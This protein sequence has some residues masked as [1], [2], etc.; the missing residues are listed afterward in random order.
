[1]I[2]VLICLK[3]KTLADVVKTG[4]KQFPEF[5]AH[6]VPAHNLVDLVSDGGYHAVMVDLDEAQKPDGGLIGHVRDTNTN[7]EIMAIGDRAL[8]EKFN[9]VKVDHN[10][11]SCIGLPLDPFELARRIVRLGKHLT[12]RHPLSI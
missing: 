8:K 10:I 1:M 5:T 11:F 7:I 9:R 2:N 12:E 4:F 6:P 3:D